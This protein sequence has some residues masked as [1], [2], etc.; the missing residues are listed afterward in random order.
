MEASEADYQDHYDMHLPISDRQ[1]RLTNMEVNMREIKFEI[2]ETIGE[3]SAS[4]KGWTK[5]LNFISWNGAAP[6][7]DVRDWAPGH[8]KMGKGI[9][10]N[11]EEAEALYVL[12]GKVLR[13]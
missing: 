4:T 3:L 8:E 2:K 1:I 10:F 11:R 9:T 12:L 13:K 5:E 6:K 7:F